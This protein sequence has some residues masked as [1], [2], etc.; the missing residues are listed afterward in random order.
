LLLFD[1]DA[2]CNGT[3]LL[4]KYGVD[5][6]IGAHEHS[7]ERN[8]AI[9]RGQVMSKDYVNPGAPAYVVAGAAGVRMLALISLSLFAQP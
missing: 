6:Y 5:L 3:D 1:L 7:Y 4:N 9:Y 8:Y 2:D